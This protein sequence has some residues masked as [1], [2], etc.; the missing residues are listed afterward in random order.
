MPGPGQLLGA[1]EPAG[2][3]PTTA[4]RLPVRRSGTWGLIQP[5]SQ[6]LSTMA[7]SMVLMAT[8]ASSMFRVQAASQGAGQMRPVNSGKLLVECRTSM[9]A[10]Q[11][12]LYTRSFQS[13]MMLLTGHPW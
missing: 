5:S 9:A 13:G 2:P 4:T 11:S 8:G 10:C 6:A 7:H 3:E 1:G 12:P